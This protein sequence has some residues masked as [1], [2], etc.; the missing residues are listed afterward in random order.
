[1]YKLVSL[2]LL[3]AVAN[4]TT[5]EGLKWLEEKAAE[6]GVEATGSGLLYKVTC[7]IRSVPLFAAFIWLSALWR[8]MQNCPLRPLLDPVRS[9]RCA[10][11]P[12]WKS[13]RLLGGTEY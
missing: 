2:A 11:L 3:V 8:I 12:A 13:T 4:A 6:E 10:H 9:H 5:P 7:D 1:M